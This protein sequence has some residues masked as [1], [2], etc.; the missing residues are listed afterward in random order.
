MRRVRPRGATLPARWRDRMPIIGALVRD[1]SVQEEIARQVA[2]LGSVQFL[3]TAAALIEAVGLHA[4]DIAI[5]ELR[6]EQGHSIKGLLEA[7]ATRPKPFPVILYDRLSPWR[8]EALRAIVRHQHIVDF[9]VRSTESLTSAVRVALRQSERRSVSTLLFPQL[10]DQ[11]PLILNPFLL[12][13]VM[14]APHEW[15]VDRLARFTGSTLRTVQR[16]LA[17][18]G[19][20]PTRAIV[21][22][23]R[24]LDAVWLMSEYGLST[25]QVLY[26]RGFSH[27][28]NIRRLTARYAGI[29][30]AQIRAGASIDPVIAAVVDRMMHRS[31]AGNPTDDTG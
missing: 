16:Y 23:V 28:T 12:M 7:L 15:S 5:T 21:G 14:K 20:A 6:D 30:P 25:R 2:P 27:S 10:L 13:A 1:V 31:R 29:T 17:R 9:V 4:I 19:W 22:S 11:A 8:V 18:A 3:P 24:A 26:A